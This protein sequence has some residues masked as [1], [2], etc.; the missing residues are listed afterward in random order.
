M[1]EP[2]LQIDYPCRWQYK[3]IGRDEGLLRAAVVEAVEDVDY[4]LVPS[5]QSATGRYLS[6]SLE[7]EV[8]DE[9]HRRRIWDRIAANEHVLYLL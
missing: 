2:E 4:E 1:D 3:L 8:R 7:L 9:P 6:L 5:K